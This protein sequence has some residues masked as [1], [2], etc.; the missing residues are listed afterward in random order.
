VSGASRESAR[1][2]AGEVSVAALGARRG[3]LARHNRLVGHY[4]LVVCGANGPTV[5]KVALLHVSQH[6]QT[7]LRRNKTA[8]HF[9]RD[10]LSRGAKQVFELDR[11]EFFDDGRLLLN[12]ALEAL[13]EFVQLTLLLVEVLNQAASALLHFVQ[14]ALE[15]HPVGGLVSLAVLDF[16]ISDGVLRVPDIVSD[17]LL[18]LNFPGAFQIYVVHIFYLVHE[19]FYVLNQDVIAR[20]QDTLLGA[21]CVGATG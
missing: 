6:S 18:D 15:T 2:T 5:R 19:A 17:E 10:V 3:R 9:L 8:H 11:A 20:D 21:T 7:T 14:A 13:F 12:A 4:D 1:L 16:V